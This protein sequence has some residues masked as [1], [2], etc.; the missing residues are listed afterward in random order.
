[1]NNDKKP[2]DPQEI[3]SLNQELLSFDLDDV[4]VEELER[5]LELAVAQMVT[6]DTTESCDTFACGT[7]K[8]AP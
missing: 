4:T 8:P 5:R 1:M 6:D 2:K 7:N 3:V